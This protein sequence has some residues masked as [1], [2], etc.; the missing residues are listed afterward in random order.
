MIRGFVTFPGLGMSAHLPIEDGDEV[1]EL[2][3]AQFEVCS[4]CDGCGSVEDETLP[5]FAL[6]ACRECSGNGGW[7]TS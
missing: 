1:I 6:T 3:S 4:V 5:F 7:W 2:S